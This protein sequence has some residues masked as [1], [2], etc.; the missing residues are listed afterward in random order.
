MLNGDDTASPSFTAPDVKNGETKILIFKLTISADGLGSATDLVSIRVV[1]GNND[2][3]ADAGPDQTVNKRTTVQLAGS[4]EDPDGDKIQYSW[5]QTAGELVK[6]SSK[7]IPAPTFTAPTVANGESKTLG[8]T[9]TVSDKYGG[10]ASD[11][12]EITVN[13]V[14]NKP[15]A[16]AGSDQIVDEQTQVT[17]AGSGK[18]PNKDKLSFRWGQ[19][20]GE[21]VELSAD[22]VSNPSFTAPVVMNG[23]TKTLTFRLAVDDGLGGKA[24]DSVIVRVNPVNEAPVADAGSDQTVSENSSGR[25]AGSGTDA[26][27]DALTFMWSQTE[28]PTVTLSSKTDKYP[29]FTAPKVDQD[30]TLTFELIANDGMV[31]SDPDTVTVTIKNVKPADLIADAGRDQVVDES[32]TVTLAGTGSDP[33]GTAVTFSWTQTEGDTVTLSSSKVAAP[34]F[35]SPEVANGETKTLVFELTV[36]DGNGRVMTDSVT[37]TVDPVNA[38]PTAKAGVKTG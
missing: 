36:T 7:T 22:D 38:D 32:V 26:D 29:T 4:G 16:N 30:T 25:L 13:P 18:D 9:L 23:E 14:N 12:V 35:T 20:G 17:L 5:K 6:I 19:T 24:S 2:P 3:T 21:P 27:G 11:S 28:G 15:S 1:T 33:S 10:S 31:N 37:I 8:F 34:T